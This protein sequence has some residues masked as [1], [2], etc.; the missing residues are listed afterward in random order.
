[1]KVQV[2]VRAVADLPAKVIRIVKA[3]KAIKKL[4]SLNQPKTL[5]QKR[6]VRKNLY[7][8]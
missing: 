7:K 3:R 5:H 1:M 6:K 8:I 2:T 4:R